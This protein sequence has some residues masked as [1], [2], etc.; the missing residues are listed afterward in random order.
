ME[1]SSTTIATKCL[2]VFLRLSL[3]RGTEKL[4]E[5]MG[6]ETEGSNNNSGLRALCY[7]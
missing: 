7:I 5:K 1:A 6:N 2:L 3:R 4:R